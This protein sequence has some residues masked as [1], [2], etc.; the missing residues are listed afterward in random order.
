MAELIIEGFDAMGC[1]WSDIPETVSQIVTGR[2]ALAAYLEKKELSKLKRLSDMIE[3][4]GSSVETLA[5]VHGRKYQLPHG[6]KIQLDEV[7]YELVEFQNLCLQAEQGNMKF[8]KSKLTNHARYLDELAEKFL[9]SVKVLRF[10]QTIAGYV[11]KQK[12]NSLTKLIADPIAC[13][14]WTSRFGHDVAHSPE[15]KDVVEFLDGYF[16]EFGETSPEFDSSCSDNKFFS[17]IRNDSS[18]SKCNFC[19]TLLKQKLCL[20]NEEVVKLHL[21][22]RFC[23]ESLLLSIRELIIEAHPS[24]SQWEIISPYLHMES[25]HE[26]QVGELT[27]FQEKALKY[28]RILFVG[29]SSHLADLHHMVSCQL[30]QQVS[31]IESVR[32]ALELAD[33][34]EVHKKEIKDGKGKIMIITNCQHHHRH[35]DRDFGTSEQDLLAFEVYN[36]L[37]MNGILS[38]GFALLTC[39]FLSHGAEEVQSL[40]TMLLKGHFLNFSISTDARELTLFI[41]SMFAVVEK[42]EKAAKKNKGK[43]KDKFLLDAFGTDIIAAMTQDLQQLNGQSSSISIKD[44]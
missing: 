3:Q 17:W 41:K 34:I 26:A 2:A 28:N 8:V 35:N 22:A 4:L 36:C 11:L 9:H 33:W 19:I 13:D 43:A 25:E 6:V 10:T 23:G 16:H 32:T 21:F 29:E 40:Q 31:K 44:S 30:L 39:P 12:E 18:W 42:T 15:F 14:Q 27:K 38:L 20:E 37:L 5:K 1:D 7:R 24:N